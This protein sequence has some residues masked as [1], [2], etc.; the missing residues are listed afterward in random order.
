M[1]VGR[2]V[3]FLSLVALP[4]AVGCSRSELEFS[5]SSFGGNAGNAG[6]AGSGGAAGSGGEGGVAGSAGAGATSGSA[7][8]GGMAGVGGGPACAT[9]SQCA[10]GDSCTT[11]RCRGGFC[12]NSPRDDD[13]DGY[14]PLV[15]GGADCN[16]QNPNTNPGSAENCFDGDD[17]DCNGVADCFDPA[18]AGVPNCGCVPS[19]GGE[20]CSNGVD[21]DCD[22]TV[23]CLDQDCQG[24]PAC[25]CAASESGQCGNGF[26]DDCDGAFDCADSDCFP[27]DACRCQAQRE[28]C[29]NGR[30]D[31]CDDLVDCADS[32]CKNQPACLCVPPGVPERCDDK[33]DN[34]CDGLVDCADL[35]CVGKPAC[36][37]CR[38][39][40]CSDGVDNDCDNLVDCADDSC[41]F[42]PSCAPTPEI[43]NNKLD[44]DN[45]GLV[46]CADPDCA[47]NPACV[48]KQSNCLSPKLITGTGQYR[49]DTRG[50]VGETKGT[51]G[52]DA[53][54][55][56]F[57]FTLSAASRVHL[58]TIGTS[59]DS[60]LYVRKGSC[61]GGKEFGCDDDSGGSS[62]AAKLDFTILYPGTYYV[63]VDGFTVDPQGGANEGPFVLNVE[64]EANPAEKC[65]DKID[66][67]GDRYVDCADPDCVSAPNCL[68]CNGGQKPGPEFGIAACTDGRDNDC[69]GVADC[70]DEDCSA[71]DYYVTEC[72]NGQDQNGNQIP[73]DFNCGCAS[74][75]DCPSGQICYT[76]T[77]WACGYPCSQFFGE[78]CPF[79]ALG[80]SCSGIT[81]Q[82]EF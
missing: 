18:C 30:D 20:N 33:R 43:C 32:D 53:G 66:N 45:D 51:C 10:D 50:N 37:M 56:V 48:V 26:D 14:A 55:A 42:D 58:D 49:G 61:K 5:P 23:D 24:T 67:D 76:H 38:P 54:E 79:V 4:L 64:I 70:A 9:D 25:G 47:N 12:E 80:S 60:V 72:C 36:Q 28:D 59:F 81:N 62:W 22:T 57:Y 68:N 65:N 44:D 82:C 11:D 39:E 2:L 21:D 13:Q 16:D 29:S 31:D 52:G 27:D 40:D 3:S 77:A 8:M 75:L 46:D 34:D 17:N 1:V 73:D 19:P 41:F 35:D 74:D 6:N 15:C 63:F 7:G 78:I 71:S 69:D